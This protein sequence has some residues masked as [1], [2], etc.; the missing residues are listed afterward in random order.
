MNSFAW[1]CL[2]G[3]VCVVQVYTAYSGIAYPTGG[4]VVRNTCNIFSV[5]SIIFSLKSI[6]FVD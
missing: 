5:K 6:F 2:R 4:H 3:F 1:F